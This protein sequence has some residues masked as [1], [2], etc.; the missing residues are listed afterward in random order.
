MNDNNNNAS[1]KSPVKM[2]SDFKLERNNYI[3]FLLY[4]REIEF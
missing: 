2:V 3:Y 1:G 4:L